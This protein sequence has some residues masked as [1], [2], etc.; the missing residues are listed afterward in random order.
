MSNDDATLRALTVELAS[1]APLA[2]PM[3]DVESSPRANRWRGPRLAFI[4]A[5]FAIV[6]PLVVATVWAAVTTADRSVVATPASA[7]FETTGAKPVALVTVD[8]VV[9]RGYFWEGGSHGVIINQGFGS[10]ATEIIR[11]ATAANGEGA[12]VLLFESRGQGES[13]GSPDPNLLASDIR[14]AVADLSTRGVDS[15]TVVAF[16]HAATAAI[17]IAADPMPQIRDVVAIFPFERYQNLN[18]LDFI[19]SISIPVDL[20]GAAHPSPSGPSV[21]ALA[22]EAPERLTTVEIFQFAGDD[23]SLLDAHMGR[24]VELIRVRSR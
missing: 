21:V 2:P 22:Q 6:V 4:V 13:E 15:V 9:L 7:I 14:S 10:D 5:G 24:L 20:I 3:P 18:A 8:G 12:S 1:A 11:L 19:G 23:I 16:S 17:T